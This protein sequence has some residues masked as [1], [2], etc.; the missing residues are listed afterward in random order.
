M[1][2]DDELGGIKYV[3]LL[4]AFL[5]F[6]IYFY[7]CLH[8]TTQLDVRIDFGCTTTSHGKHENNKLSKTLQS[9]VLVTRRTTRIGEEGI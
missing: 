5:K 2:R 9:D 7:F 8:A 6:G 4:R 1:A 3:R